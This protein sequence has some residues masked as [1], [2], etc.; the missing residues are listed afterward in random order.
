[1]IADGGG[2][3]ER[4]LG[5]ESK[6]IVLG[7]VAGFMQLLYPRVVK[8]V[9]RVILLLYRACLWGLMY[10]SMGGGGGGVFL[11]KGR[12]LAGGVPHLSSWTNLS[13]WMMLDPEDLTWRSGLRKSIQLRHF[14]QQTARSD[15]P[16]DTPWDISYLSKMA[17]NGLNDKK[18]SSNPR[19]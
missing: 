8:L 17:C 13:S 5:Q 2:V 16:T 9:C 12:A 6:G 11:H 18:V 15:L 7:G 19:P 10:R 14:A 1:M 3:S 4:R